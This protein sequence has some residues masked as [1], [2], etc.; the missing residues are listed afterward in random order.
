MISVSFRFSGQA[1]NREAPER[2]GVSY[3]E[4]TNKGP[5]PKRR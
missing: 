3:G 1:L 2:E 4:F 5:M